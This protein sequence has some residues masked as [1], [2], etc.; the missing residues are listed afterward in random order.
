V[1]RGEPLFIDLRNEFVGTRDG[2]DKARF[3]RAAVTLAAAIEHRSKDELEAGGSSIDNLLR[4]IAR[5]GPSSLLPS[6]T[7]AAAR[8]FSAE[9]AAVRGDLATLRSG[10]EF[11]GI[12]KLRHEV[13][14][15]RAEADLPTTAKFGF[16]RFILNKTIPLVSTLNSVIGGPD[17][18]FDLAKRAFRRE[19]TRFWSQVAKGL[20]GLARE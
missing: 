20:E 19:A 15:H 4:L 17:P 14:A 5:A 10:P 7:S 2:I 8:R 9:V 13:L 16:E 12:R 6:M 18:N 1:F 11:R 3:R